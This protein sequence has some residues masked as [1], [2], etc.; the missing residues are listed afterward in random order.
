M[1][2]NQVHPV[3]SATRCTLPENDEESERS[4]RIFPFSNIKKKECYLAPVLAL[5]STHQ[6]KKISCCS[7][8]LAR[9][10]NHTQPL[11]N[12]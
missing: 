7:V 6:G 5:D 9:D 8:I 2:P 4:H 1:G 11:V 10:R 12:K 3:N